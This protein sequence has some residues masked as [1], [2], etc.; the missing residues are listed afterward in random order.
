MSGAAAP[1]RRPKKFVRGPPEH[2]PDFSLVESLDP[3]TWGRVCANLLPAYAM[4]F[5]LIAA[6]PQRVG[7]MEFQSALG[8][9]YHH[10]TRELERQEGV[11]LNGSVYMPIQHWTSLALE[12]PDSNGVPELPPPEMLVISSDKTRFVNLDNWFEPHQQE[13]NENEPISIRANLYAARVRHVEE[14]IRF[15][16][17]VDDTGRVYQT[18]HGVS[19]QISSSQV[20]AGTVDVG[21]N[22]SSFAEM[23]ENITK[24]WAWSLKLIPSAWYAWPPRTIHATVARLSKATAITGAF[25]AWL[26][27]PMVSLPC[28]DDQVSELIDQAEVS[29]LVICCPRPWFNALRSVRQGTD[30]GRRHR[31]GI[32]NIA[33]KSFIKDDG[34]TRDGSVKLVL[35]PAMRRDDTMCGLK[36][37]FGY[38]K[39]MS[40]REGADQISPLN[41][42]NVDTLIAALAFCFWFNTSGEP[43]PHVTMLNTFMLKLDRSELN[44]CLPAA[45]GGSGTNSHFRLLG[46]GEALTRLQV[47]EK[48]TAKQ[49]SKKSSKLKTLAF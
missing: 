15:G 22:T 48:K 13:L 12:N 27:L 25:K 33:V 17:V 49:L 21:S 38:F 34:C 23:C 46:P 44:R 14:S 19:S 4:P 2:D 42:V 32:N 36:G 7:S 20:S 40:Q 16:I 8:C 41:M 39:M 10:N 5:G 45:V 35:D 31:R 37:P 18:T 43:N 9:R 26:K 1:H 11:F 28:L 47:T 3:D 29:R 24:N 6:E 30:Q